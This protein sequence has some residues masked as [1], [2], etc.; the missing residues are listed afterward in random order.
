MI[1]PLTARAPR[2]TMRA[3]RAKQAPRI[4]RPR[5]RETPFS[6]W[7]DASGRSRD[8]IAR[9]LRIKRPWLDKLC[10]LERRPSLDLAF[11]I[12][13]LTSGKVPARSWRSVPRHSRS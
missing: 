5:K 7:I 4:G 8:E 3:M 13:D 2:P 1:P 10:R 9:R 11:D 12:E 6:R